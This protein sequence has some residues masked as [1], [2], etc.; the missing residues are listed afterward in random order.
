MK[1]WFRN[2]VV[3]NKKSYITLGMVLLVVLLLSAVAYFSY[4]FYT[5]TNTNLVITGTA[6]IETSD[7]RVRIYLQ[8]LQGSTPVN[9][10]A[11]SKNQAVP[12][13]YIFNPEKSS[14]DNGSYFAAVDNSVLTLSYGQIGSCSAYFDKI[15]STDDLSS[16]VYISNDN[17]KTFQAKTSTSITTGYTFSP[18]LS[19]CLSLNT[20]TERPTINE[21]GQASFKGPG[22]C[23]FVYVKK[24]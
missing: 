22:V 5:T 18:E 14:C 8:E 16:K 17:G 13:G 15:T 24:S 6:N 4:A 1:E 12:T 23:E 7:I 10:Y 9:S 11:E 20:T 3:P 19:D 21:N 2:K